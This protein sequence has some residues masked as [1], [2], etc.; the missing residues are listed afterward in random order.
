VTQPWWRSAVIYQVYL[1]SFADAN[2]DGIGDLAGLRSR[3]GYLAELGVDGVWLNPCYP[4]PQKD[5]GYD[6]ADYTG[7]EPDYGDLAAFDAFVAD[8][9]ERGMKVLMDLVPN[10]CSSAHRW[11]QAALAA[12]PGS[13]GVGPPTYQPARPKSGGCWRRRRTAIRQ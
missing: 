6:V 2:G 13:P 1:R 8:A 7:I 12:G 3:L 4:S 9:H 5:H 11:F 10:H